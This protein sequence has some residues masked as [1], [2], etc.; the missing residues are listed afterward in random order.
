MFEPARTNVA[1]DCSVM[2]SVMIPASTPAW[3][4]SA[5]MFTVRDDC[6]K[7]IGSPLCGWGNAVVAKVTSTV[8]LDGGTR[9]APVGS[10]TVD[11][12][13]FAV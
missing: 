6:D 12:Q 9:S 1:C 4:T 7:V 13:S 3:M 2:P 11:V 8:A 5:G 10:F